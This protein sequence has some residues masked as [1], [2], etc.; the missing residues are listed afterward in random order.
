MGT[1]FVDLILDKLCGVA[2]ITLNRPD[3]L[4]ALGPNTTLEIYQALEEAVRDPGIKVIV[5]TGEGRA[6]CAGGDF[7]DN[8]LEG[9]KKTT[10]ERRQ[11]IRAGVNKLVK[12]VIECEKP[13]I[14]SINGLA[15]GGGT[16]IALACDIRIASEK[17]KFR[18]PFSGIGLTPEFGCTYLLPRLVGLGKAL[19]LLYTGDF[20]GAEEALRIGLINQIVAHEELKK[21]TAEFAEKIAEK[22]AAALGMIKS[23]IYRSLSNDLATQLELEAFAI[24]TAFKT[25]EHEKAVRAFLRNHKKD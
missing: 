18:L 5:L 10:L 15:V 11:G 6:F 2:T 4:N 3:R 13:V 9:F 21:A 16:T 14:A 22:P 19:E 8:F 7:K 24:S 20:V 17:A 25:E 12:F 1:H 23:L